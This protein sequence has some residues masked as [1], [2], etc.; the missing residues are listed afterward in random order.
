[1]ESLRTQLPWEVSAKVF[2]WCI[3]RLVAAGALVREDSVVR[4]PTHRISLD[5]GDRALGARV[6]ELLAQGRFTPPDLRQLEETTGAPRKRLTDVLGV[7]EGEGRVAR[8]APDLWYARAA[9]DEAVGL[10]AEHCR[11]HG[12]IA[13]GTFRDLIGASRR[14]AIAFLDWCD[15]TGVTVR[16]GDLRKLRHDAPRDRARVS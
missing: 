7:L 4:L 13:A 14:F 6:G 16:V 15:R 5:S 10:L 3:D 9:A 2:R 8:I 1:M 12:A 11:A